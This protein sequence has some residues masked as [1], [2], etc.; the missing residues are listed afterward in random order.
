MTKSKSPPSKP[1]GG[2]P[3]QRRCDWL[4]RVPHPCQGLVSDFSLFSWVNSYEML[5]SGKAFRAGIKE[6][7][8]LQAIVKGSASA[9]SLFHKPPKPIF[10]TFEM[11]KCTNPFGY[12][13]SFKE[14]SSPVLSCL[15]KTIFLSRKPLSSWCPTSTPTKTSIPAPRHLSSCSWWGWWGSNEPLLDNSFES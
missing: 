1:S 5:F 9:S 6:E 12:P 8:S 3:Q 14:L 11:Y 4:L 10:N 2:R 15:L 7:K 13:S